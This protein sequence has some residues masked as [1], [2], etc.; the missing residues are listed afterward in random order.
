MAA[1]CRSRGAA[2]MEQAMAQCKEQVTPVVRECVR[3]R[4]RADE[5]IRIPISL[6]PGAGDG[7]DQGLR[8]QADR[9]G[10]LQEQSARCRQRACVRAPRK[11][12]SAGQK[13]VIPPR[14]IADIT[15][16]LDQEKPDP[17]RLKKLQAAADAPPPG[18]K[19]GRWRRRISITAAPL[20]R[21]ELGR[22][23]RGG[24]RW[25]ARR[26]ARHR[27]GRSARA[28]QLSAIPWPCNMSP[29]GEPKVALDRVISRWPRTASAARKGWLF[30]GYRQIADDLSRARRSGSRADLCPE[31]CRRFG[32]AP[33]QSG[34]TTA[35]RKTWESSVEDAKAM[36]CRSARPARRRASVLS[37]RGSASARGHR[38]SAH[39]MIATPRAQTRSSGGSC[40]CF[41]ARGSSRGMGRIAEAETD[42][43]RA[44]LNRLKATGKY[45]SANRDA[46]S[47]CSARC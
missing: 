8:R 3:Q 33:A 10:R 37:A 19:S 26:A 16:I 20:V 27:Q 35:T 22:I 14:T 46:T 15:A 11:Q 18:G 34:A 25:R 40:C 23:P 42:A 21:A 41:R 2:T 32:K 38:S 45:T 5:A 4:W 28:E 44:L 39:A 1:V 6:V 7:A 30:I 24:G 29:V 47:P 17:A 43:R 36:L 9:R 13:R 12:P 31:S